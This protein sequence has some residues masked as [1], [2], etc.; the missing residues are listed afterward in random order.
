MM[1]WLL[2]MLVTWLAKKLPVIIYDFME[3]YFVEVIMFVGFGLLGLYILG[4]L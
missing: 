4:L 2:K 1:K 3:K